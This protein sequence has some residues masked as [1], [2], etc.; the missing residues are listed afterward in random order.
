M[1]PF[2]PPPYLLAPPPATILSPFSPL[3]E[4]CLEQGTEKPSCGLGQ[5]CNVSGGWSR[6]ERKQR[7]WT[8]APVPNPRGR[9]SNPH[10][11]MI[12][13]PPTA[14][15]P[16]FARELRAAGLPSSIVPPATKHNDKLIASQAQ[17]RRWADRDKQA[18]CLHWE[19]RAYTGEH[20]CTE[21]SNQRG[22]SW[23]SPS[24]ILQDSDHSDQ[25]TE[26][27]LI[28]GPGRRPSYK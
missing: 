10:L 28:P 23:Q 1:H 3:S 16:R 7:M 17:G 15:G 25:L 11:V 24:E 22:D 14:L 12:L 6:T 4:L 20:T 8:F 26:P 9:L 2:S 19:L 5:M 27:L 18:Q 21:T 13:P